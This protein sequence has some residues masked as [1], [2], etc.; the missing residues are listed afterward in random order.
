MPTPIPNQSPS[1]TG[2]IP[3]Q[4]LCEHSLEP[5]IQPKV[6]WAHSASHR[7]SRATHYWLEAIAVHLSHLLRSAPQVDEIGMGI[8]HFVQPRGPWEELKRLALAS[9]PT[10]VL[11]PSHK[12][13]ALHRLMQLM[14]EAM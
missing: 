1:R 14:L 12:A 2:L 3:T 4:T 7:P 6:A 5:L 13:Q 10:S 8:E 9:R 11:P